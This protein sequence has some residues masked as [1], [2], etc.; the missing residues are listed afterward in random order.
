MDVLV[1]NTRRT[2]ENEVLMRINPSE[3][4]ENKF[5]QA[6]NKFSKYAPFAQD[7]RSVPSLAHEL[8]PRIVVF[9]MDA[10][11]GICKDASSFLKE[12]VG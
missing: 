2:A 1:V 3:F 9:S 5:L 10:N 11:G 8:P 12:I 7:Y 6:R 4:R